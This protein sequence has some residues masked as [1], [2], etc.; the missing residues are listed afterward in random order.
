[1]DTAGEVHPACKGESPS[2]L[3]PKF[4]SRPGD[5]YP[6]LLEFFLKFWT[7]FVV[8]FAS[9]LL[10]LSLGSFKI[11]FEMVFL[12]FVQLLERIWTVF[13]EF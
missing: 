12:L 8:L 9:S 4:V 3:A 1:M 6:P 13:N 11:H 10:F 2:P 7:P 5:A